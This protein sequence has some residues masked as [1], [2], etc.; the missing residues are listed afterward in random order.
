MTALATLVLAGVGVRYARGVD[1]DTLSIRDV[2]QRVVS[3][4][5]Q[6]RVKKCLA[7]IAPAAGDFR[8]ELKPIFGQVSERINLVCL[9]GVGGRNGLT[10][11]AGTADCYGGFYTKD[12]QHFE[13]IFSVRSCPSPVSFLAG[14]KIRE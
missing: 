1:D 13:P 4:I 12:G 10:F 6:A 3:R 7:G 2:Q 9:G 5:V 14:A 8:D 11:R